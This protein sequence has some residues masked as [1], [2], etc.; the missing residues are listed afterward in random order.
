MIK[1]LLDNDTLV[2]FTQG[3]QKGFNGVYDAYYP[4]IFYFAWKIAGNREE[5]EDI[6]ADAFYILFKIHDRFLTEANIRA[7][8]FITTRNNSLKYLRSVRSRKTYSTDFSLPMDQY[9][10]TDIP[11][12][13]SQHAIFETGLIKEMY[14]AIQHL[15]EK[16][17]QILTMI[18]FDGMDTSAVAEQLSITRETVRSQKRHALEQLRQR[19]SND[20]TV[21]S[22]IIALVLL[23]NISLLDSGQLFS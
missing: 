14:E 21:I 16:S 1:E 20:Q 15:P 19:F 9:L 10:E 12:E 4:E 11:D 3:L 6:T 22:I 23:E 7:F 2:A 8:L 13:L 17:R 18:Y 5:A